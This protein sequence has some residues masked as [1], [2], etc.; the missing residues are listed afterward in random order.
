MSRSHRLTIA[1]GLADVR[2]CLIETPLGPL[3][4][5]G[6]NGMVE[7]LNFTDHAG[8]ERNL[9]EYALDETAFDEARRQIELYF[10]GSNARF[11]LQL[12]LRGSQFELEVWNALMRIPYG[13]TASYK[14]VA[15]MIGRP[16]AARAAGATIGR[17]RISI[18]VPCHRVIGSN[19]N[20]TGYAWGR[21]RKEW[22]LNHENLHR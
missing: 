11:D 9:E 12:T 15:E 8:W 20:L 13:A 1:T 16:L 18:V 4:L 3:L 17:N 5:S 2:H 19:G 7:G 14:E 21:D 22:L 6:R 10:E